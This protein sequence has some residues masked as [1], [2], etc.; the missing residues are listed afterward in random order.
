MPAMQISFLPW[1]YDD[2]VVQHARPVLDK[3]KILR[4]SNE[5]SQHVV[6]K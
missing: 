6:I 4:Q 5:D 2:E 1:I 3:K